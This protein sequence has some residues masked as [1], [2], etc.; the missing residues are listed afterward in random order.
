V[1]FGV[2]EEDDAGDF[3]EVILPKTTGWWLCALA[4]WF[5]GVLDGCGVG[6]WGEANGWMGGGWTY[7]VDD[8]RDR[9]W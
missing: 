4:F 9:R 6:N 8:R 1:V 2:D 7:L 3:R 5:W